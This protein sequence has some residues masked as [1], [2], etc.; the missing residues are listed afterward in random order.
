MDA[1]NVDTE[2]DGV[3][4]NNFGPVVYAIDVGFSPY[5]GERS[6][7]PDDRTAEVPLVKSCIRM[8]TCPLV[9]WLMLTPGIPACVA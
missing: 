3:I 2:F 8:P 5:P 1:P 7:V 4:A 6:G 9:N